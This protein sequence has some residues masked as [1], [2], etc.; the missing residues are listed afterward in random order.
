MPAEDLPVATSRASMFTHDEP[1]ADLVTSSS[2]ASRVP[3][4]P[5]RNGISDK[6]TKQSILPVLL[7][8]STLR[9]VAFRT[10]TK[11]HSLTITSS[12]LQALATF[13]GRNCV[14]RWREDGLAE[15]VLDEIAKAWKR[16]GGGV[17]VE[18]GTNASLK[19]ILNSFENNMC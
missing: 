4:H 16:A 7:P 10:F 15:L 17:I 6:P 12:S 19:S 18:E 14:S 8:P 1:A 13:V 9:P 2:F 3:L 11:K 5:A